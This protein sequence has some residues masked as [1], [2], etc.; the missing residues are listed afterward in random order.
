M[1][2]WKSE[3]YL[4]PTLTVARDL[5]GKYLVRNLNGE[6]LIGRISETEAYIAVGD[7]A[8]HA[9]NYKRTPR[10]ET[11]FAAGGTAYIYLIYGMHACLN[12]VTEP[13]G[14][15]CAVLIRGIQPR[16]DSDG[17][18]SR[19]FGRSYAELTP[20]QRKNLLNGPGKVCQG[21]S[22]TTAHNGTSLLDDILF[23]CD[24]LTDLGLTPFPGDE[25]P[26]NIK[27]GKRIGVEY[28]EECADYLWRFYL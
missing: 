10:T 1:S 14:E 28:A 21:I 16:S 4:R 23:V 11:M 17:F 22:L 2:K 24:D 13:E 19:R 27:T 9:Y 5:L 12:L 8:C 25:L 15:P 18:A 7:K 6:L 20:Y 26:L 3:E